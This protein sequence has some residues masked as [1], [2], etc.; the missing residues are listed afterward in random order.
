MHV[1]LSAL[2]CT[3]LC[4]LIIKESDLKGR[5]VSAGIL[6]NIDYVSS[7]FCKGK[8]SLAAMGS[9]QNTGDT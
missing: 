4:Q 2:Q 1:V 7:L 8:M 5:S 3:V 6:G 9:V